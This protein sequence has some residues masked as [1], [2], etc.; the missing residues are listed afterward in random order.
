MFHLHAGQLTRP[1]SVSA[2]V[3]ILAIGSKEHRRKVR[4]PNLSNQGSADMQSRANMCHA[5]SLLQGARMAGSDRS[6]QYRLCTFSIRQTQYAVWMCLRYCCAA[7]QT[8]AFAEWSSRPTSQTL[9]VGVITA[10]AL[11]RIKAS[12]GDWRVGVARN[13]RLLLMFQHLGD[14]D[15]VSG[16]SRALPRMSGRADTREE[17]RKTRPRGCW[18]LST[19]TSS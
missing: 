7:V 11:A 6:M 14:L 8:N 13:T 1:T 12:A 18:D 10:A 19:S 4:L 9:A 17:R 2:C 5:F 3:G 15:Q 16:L